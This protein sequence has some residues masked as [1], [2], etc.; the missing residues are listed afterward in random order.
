MGIKAEA[1][2]IS[3]GFKAAADAVSGM[4]D[5]AKR[6]ANK[7]IREAEAKAR[8]KIA[9]AEAKV[10][11]AELKQAAKAIKAD[12]KDAV[13]AIK[14][15]AEVVAET[16]PWTVGRIVSKP[17]R[18]LGEGLAWPFKAS[19]KVGFGAIDTAGGLALKPVKL[20]STGIGKAFTKAPLVS[21]LVVAGTAAVGVGSWFA[22]RESKNLQAQGEAIQQ[23]QAMQAAQPR[24]MN[25]VSPDEAAMLSAMQKQGQNGGSKAEAVMAARSQVPAPENAN[26]AAL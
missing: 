10:A 11:K 17:F 19:A 24:Y 8:E 6:E 3:D 16:K 12:A 5:P 4:F 20:V 14:S 25:S 13:R 9:K 21:S 23:M 15:G 7:A 1:Q 22:N 26:I 2:G 18:L